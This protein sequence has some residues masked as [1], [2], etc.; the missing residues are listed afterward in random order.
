MS[1]LYS[2][3][4]LDDFYDNI[5]NLMDKVN[6]KKLE[7]VEPT[8]SE[9]KNVNSIIMDFIKLNKR[10][11]Y[12]GVALEY[13][14]QDKNAEENIYQE[15]A[16]PDIDFYSADPIGDLIK[17]CNDL[18]DKGFKH[19]RGREAIHKES[20]SV[21]VNNRHYCNI[22]YVPKNIY[23]KIQFKQIKDFIIVHP[24]FLLIDYL[25]VLTDPI[26]SYLRLKEKNA[27]GRFYLIQK[28]FSLPYVNKPF[29]FDF[30]KTSEKTTKEILNTVLDF[31]KEKDS[32][33]HCG[34]LAYNYYLEESKMLTKRQNTKFK[35]IDIPYYE[36]VSTNYKE[37]T[38]N[39]INN[40]K[41][42]FTSEEIKVQE[43]YPFSQYLGYSATITYNDILICVIY[44]NYN[45]C[46][47]FKKYNNH[48]VGSFNYVILNALS[49]LMKYRTEDD[50]SSKNIQYMFISHLVE[51]RK[52]YF[53]LHKKTIFD[54]TPFEDFCLDYK[55]QTL[56]PEKERQLIGEAR[57]KKNK[58]FMFSY[59]PS[60]KKDTKE[61][62]EIKYTFLNTSG[63]I[64]NNSKRS[65][66]FSNNNE[67]EN[68]EL[69][70]NSIEDE[71]N[72]E[73]I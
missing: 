25:R 63:N 28:Y 6:K 73:D 27:F 55:G 34:F 19:V 51:L 70:E 47:P 1:T 56:S 17:L 60:L 7:E 13:F 58:P 65:K 69:I 45:R 61:S 49:S 35:T 46:I 41:E 57:K 12:G 18:N 64:I 11:I 36:I 31:T 42:K 40:L 54:N 15:N 44:D 26:I 24:H 68:I 71:E 22:S 50:E 4:D 48:F 37:D 33:V 29:E 21:Y 52:F 72:N 10:K 38:L 43:N 39:L 16:F 2:E 62:I 20:Y 53:K 8:I 23:N 66:L 30:D 14:L 3:K 5:D 59:E 67:E 32:M 9:I